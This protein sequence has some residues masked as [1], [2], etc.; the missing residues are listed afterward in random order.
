M[1]NNQINIL[2]IFSKMNRGG[3]ELRTIDLL[4]KI[5][6]DAYSFYFCALSGQR[7]ELDDLIAGMGGQMTYCKFRSITFPYRFIKLLKQHRI[8]VVHSNMYYFS[9]LILMLAKIAGIKVRI[10]HFRTTDSGKQGGR[11]QRYK[12]NLM[13]S[14]IN[15]YATIILGVSRSSIV[16]SMGKDI[17][18]DKRTEVIY[19]GID[20]NKINGP[21][22]EEKSLRSKYRLGEDSKIVIHIG[23]LVEAKNHIKLINIFKEMVRKGDYYLFLVG[24]ENEPTAGLIREK[25][26]EYAIRDRVFFLG[27]QSNVYELLQQADL[28]IYPSIREGLPGAVLEALACGVPVLGSSIDP[29]VELASYFKVLK[30]LPLEAND[31]LWASE[32]VGLIGE[33]ERMS[34]KDHAYEEFR[35]TPFTIDKAAEQYV[36]LMDKAMK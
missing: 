1:A 5:D 22:D 21:V 31:E 8:H 15:R 4:D 33:S 25:I 27:V 14:L 6:L 18:N 36:Q 35:N 26:E 17:V 11:L 16:S 10:A 13:K 24:K 20:L 12:Y 34:F 3:A 2:H 29:I 30:Y 32:A 19:N 23:R 7:G 9:G 28:M